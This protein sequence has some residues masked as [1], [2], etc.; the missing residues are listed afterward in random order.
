MRT[1]VKPY[2][3]RAYYYETDQMGIVHHANYVRWFEEARIDFMKQM[4][5]DYRLLEAQGI[6]IPVT[7]FSCANKK[8]VHFDDLVTVTVTPT[9]FN[10]VRSAF[11]YMVTLE[12]G[13]VAATGESHHCFL[14]TNM[15]PFSLKRTFPD[16]YEKML[17]MLEAGDN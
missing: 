11:S 13:D 10:G 9:E 4:D 5:L 7:G 3:R 16:I 14:N 1:V 15:R 8:S 12:N 2:V 17:A 6:I